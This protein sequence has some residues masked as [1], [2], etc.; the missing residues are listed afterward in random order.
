[1][2]PGA[3]RSGPLERAAPAGVAGGWQGARSRSQRIRPDL[4]E[5][6]TPEGEWKPLAPDKQYLFPLTSLRFFA[7]TS[8]VVFHIAKVHLLPFKASATMALGVS[9][10][11]VLSGFIL[12]YNYRNLEGKLP[13]FY[14]SRI[15]RLWPVHILTIVIMF[16]LMPALALWAVDPVGAKIVLTNI[17]LLQAWVPLRGYVYSFNAVSWSISAEMFFYLV[18]PLLLLVRRI[19]LLLLILF[20]GTL[21]VLTYADLFGPR[22]DR[23]DPWSVDWIVVALHFPPMRLLEFSAGM[24]AARLF[25]S[26]PVDW[27]FG[28]ATGREILCLAIMVLSVALTQRVATQGVTGQWISQCGNFAAFALVIVVFAIGRG[29]LSSA[30][31]HPVLVW[32][33]DISFAMYM[34]HKIVIDFAIASQMTVLWGKTI[35]VLVI[36]TVTVVGSH[37]LWWGWE[38]PAQRTLLR[39]FAGP[40]PKRTA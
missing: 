30:L 27:S 1:M 23:N 8:I 10:F 19:G 12:Q 9:F 40:V 14:L 35:S 18:F 34:F 32:L 31:R 20:A 3:R 21:L 15:A 26:R 22:V 29:A 17:F 13:R 7:A 37:L 24:A 33:G 4:S 16:L 28:S 6:P 39:W 2:A 38:R 11:F 36:V 25:L 5:E